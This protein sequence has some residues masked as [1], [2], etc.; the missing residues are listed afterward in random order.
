MGLRRDKDGGGGQLRWKNNRKSDK[1]KIECSSY[2]VMFFRHNRGLGRN[3]NVTVTTVY[4]VKSF[5]FIL[6]LFVTEMIYLNLITC[7][8]VPIIPCRYFLQLAWKGGARDGHT[9]LGRNFFSQRISIF[10]RPWGI[11][12]RLKSHPMVE[13]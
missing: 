12:C 9:R 3:Y 10:L 4:Q 13:I 2:L 11:F 5:L 7:S 1:R 6:F 8:I